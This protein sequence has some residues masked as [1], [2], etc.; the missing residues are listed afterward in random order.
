MNNEWYYVID[1][2]YTYAFK[3]RGKKKNERKIM[4][5]SDTK[6]CNFLVQTVCKE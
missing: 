1:V 6:K 4:I 3:R 2:I 5:L